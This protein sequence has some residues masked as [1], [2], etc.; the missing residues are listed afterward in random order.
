[1]C[2]VSY[3]FHKCNSIRLYRFFQAFFLTQTSNGLH[4]L[5]YPSL[6]PH[7]VY[8][9]QK[10]C[11]I[12]KDQTKTSHG[13]ELI[14][15][16]NQPV[17]VQLYDDQKSMELLRVKAVDGN[18]KIFIFQLDSPFHIKKICIFFIQESSKR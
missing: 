1:M 6:K 15:I 4:L 16:A 10:L 13:I 17:F 2:L 12:F 11:G 7:N 18:G 9:S 14:G 8:T 5:E 3:L